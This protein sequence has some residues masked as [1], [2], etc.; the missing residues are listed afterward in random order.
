MS[1]NGRVYDYNLHLKGSK[2]SL[3]NPETHHISTF[4]L[5]IQ[6]NACYSWNLSHSIRLRIFSGGQF[7]TAQ[8]VVSDKQRGR[9]ATHRRAPSGNWRKLEKTRGQLV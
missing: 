1:K 9:E 2:E 5:T 6:S 3:V 8:A 4:D 7:T